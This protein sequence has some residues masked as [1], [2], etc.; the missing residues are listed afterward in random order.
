MCK[1][2]GCEYEDRFS[3][4]CQFQRNFPCMRDDVTEDARADLEDEEQRREDERQEAIHEVDLLRSEVRHLGAGLGYTLT[5]MEADTLNEEVRALAGKLR[6][7]LEDFQWRYM[8]AV[9]HT[10]RALEA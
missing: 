6:E 7:A 2:M 8:V 3:G 5:K 4:E 9:T 10:K 1:G